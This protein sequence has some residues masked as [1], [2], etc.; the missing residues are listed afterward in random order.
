MK[1]MNSSYKKSP[2]RKSQHYVQQAYLKNFACNK[3]KT[4]IWMMDKWEKK[5]F[6]KP[7]EIRECAQFRFFYPQEL[8]EWLNKNVENDGI[9]IIRKL[10]YHQD[11]NKLSDFEKKKL[12][13]W[14]CVQYIRTPDFVRLVIDV[15]NK[16][17]SYISQNKEFLLPK[18]ILEVFRSKNPNIQLLKRY[19][20]RIVKLIWESIKKK[21]LYDYNWL[22]KQWILFKNKTSFPYFTSDNPVILWKS[23][24][25]YIHNVCEF[26]W[27]ASKEKFLPQSFSLSLERGIIYFISLNPNTILLLSE[28]NPFSSS[29]L[30][31]D[32]ISQVF[33]MN[34]MISAQSYRYIFSNENFFEHAFMTIDEIPECIKKNKRITTVREENQRLDY[35]VFRVQ[36]SDLLNDVIRYYDKIDEERKET[37]FDSD[38]IL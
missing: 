3:K 1:K 29:I 20:Y 14:I 33:N 5:I 4:H 16:L 23:G 18:E 2:L 32:K 17:L 36:N 34:R 10:L 13:E 26:E 7:Q 31:Q 9:T 6:E 15:F 22:E 11:Y 12:L 35:E 21:T 19:Y 37:I 24:D 8:E 25:K 27:F 38:F 28:K 30:E